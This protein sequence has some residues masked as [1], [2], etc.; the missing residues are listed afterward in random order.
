M[1]YNNNYIIITKALF[2]TFRASQALGASDPDPWKP[3]VYITL[4]LTWT[5][6]AFK[7][8]GAKNWLDILKKISK[9]W[10]LMKRVLN[11]M[12]HAQP[13]TGA[14][15][16]WHLWSCSLLKEAKFHT[17]SDYFA[18]Y[19]SFGFWLL[20]VYFS[21]ISVPHFYFESLHLYFI[22]F[23][24]LPKMLLLHIVL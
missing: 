10:S 3:Q 1:Y 13:Q 19:Q 6:W 2:R 24:F 11:F 20:I 8:P 21:K 23:Y 4:T 12:P 9:S 7:P 17:G 18:A 22:L 14:Y 5:H 16:C 15:S